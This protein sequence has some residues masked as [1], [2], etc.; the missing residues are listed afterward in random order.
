MICITSRAVVDLPQPDS[1]TMPS[2]SPLKTSRSTPSTARTMPRSLPDQLAPAA[3]MLHQPADREQRL[4]RSAAI[5]LGARRLEDR[6]HERTSMAERRP[7]DSR[8]N[9]IEVMKIIT[10]GSAATAGWT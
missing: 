6:A 3:E 7:S 5:A 2:V 4:G 1:P 8:L 10:P 9:E